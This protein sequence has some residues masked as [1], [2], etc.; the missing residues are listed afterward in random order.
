VQAVTA[1]IYYKYSLFVNSGGGGHSS[2]KCPAQILCSL[3][4]T[5]SL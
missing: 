4:F 3:T 2:V 5:L 1:L